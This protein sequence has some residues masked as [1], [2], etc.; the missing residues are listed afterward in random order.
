MK[1]TLQ[2]QRITV[3]SGKCYTCHKA[4]LYDWLCLCLSL[5]WRTKLVRHC[6]N[7]IVH[8]GGKIKYIILEQKLCI[9]R[10]QIT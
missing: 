5:Q 9:I 2:D 4:A 6:A 8:G 3:C 7:N 1:T 10:Q